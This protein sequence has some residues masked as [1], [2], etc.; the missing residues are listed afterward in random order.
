MAGEGYEDEGL[1]GLRDAHQWLLSKPLG[2]HRADEDD[3]ETVDALVEEA[4]LEGEG[5]ARH[6]SF[7]KTLSR[8][9]PQEVSRS[10][11]LYQSA[12][13]SV[14][15]FSRPTMSIK[16]QWLSWSSSPRPLQPPRDRSLMSWIPTVSSRPLRPRLTNS[17][18]QRMDQ[19]RLLP[20]SSMGL[21]GAHRMKT[22]SES[23]FEETEVPLSL[24]HLG[25][26]YASRPKTPNR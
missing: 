11:R 4:Q 17:E 16:S 26:P 9:V 19:G 23:S 14:M 13:H 12:R 15:E 6:S 5:R 7:R 22:N 25:S 18:S 10:G 21:N 1:L 2:S 3:E 20:N 8:E 24:V